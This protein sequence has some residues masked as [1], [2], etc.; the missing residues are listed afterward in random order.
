MIDREIFDYN[1]ANSILTAKGL[2]KE[3]NDS[4]DEATEVSHRVIQNLL[5][6]RGWELERQVCQGVTQRWDACKDQV[7]VTIE[8]STIDAIHRDFFRALML[9]NK[10]TLDVLVCIIST[11]KEPT[12]KSVK[13]NIQIFRQILTF[14]ILLIGIEKIR[15]SD[16]ATSH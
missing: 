7:I 12:F 14:P 5:A 3:L 16:C 10:G 4:L 6:Q 11:A 9:N 8:F 1:E 13:N 15:M 2:L